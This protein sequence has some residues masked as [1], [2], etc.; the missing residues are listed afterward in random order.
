MTRV[1]GGTVVEGVEGV[2]EEYAETSGV[3]RGECGGD[4]IDR[5][6]EVA[7]DVLLHL[8]HCVLEIG[9]RRPHLL[10]HASAPH[11]AVPFPFQISTWARILGV[12]ENYKLTNSV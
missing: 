5:G 11:P 1:G 9:D 6:L 10:R 2:G 3:L 7:L 8:I 12:G 4:F